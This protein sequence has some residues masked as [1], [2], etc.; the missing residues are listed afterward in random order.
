MIRKLAVVGAIVTGVVVLVAGPR[1]RTSRS[2]ATGEVGADGVVATTLTSRTRRRTRARSRSQLVFP[3]SPELDHRARPDAV[4]GW[5]AT[6]QKDA[7]GDGHRGHVDR[8]S[9]DR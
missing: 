6:V 2:S 5:T 4:N 3:A 7:A 8:W 9:A 1:S